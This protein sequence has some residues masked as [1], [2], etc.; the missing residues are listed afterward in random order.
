MPNAKKLT[1]MGA[2]FSALTK[3]YEIIPSRASPKVDMA[4]SKLLRILS[5]FFIGAIIA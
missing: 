1:L 5:S 4:F 2:R 3:A